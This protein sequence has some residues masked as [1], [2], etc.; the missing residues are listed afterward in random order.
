MQLS[1]SV[2]LLIVAT[3]GAVVQ[4]Q[5][6]E[7]PPKRKLAKLDLHPVWDLTAGHVDLYGDPLPE[8]A[9]TRIGSTRFR[10]NDNVLALAY[11][12]DGRTI[13]AAGWDGLVLW[14]AA[15]GR[16]LGRFVGAAF[17]DVQFLADGKR[18]VTLTVDGQFHF[19]SLSRTVGRPQVGPIAD[20]HSKFTQCAGGLLA[21]CKDRRIVLWDTKLEKPVRTFDE[22]CFGVAASAD[23]KRLASWNGERQ[24][25][26]I[27]LWNPNTGERLRSFSSALKRGNLRS[28]ALSADGKWIAGIDADF[29]RESSVRVWNSE[30]G[31]ETRTFRTSIPAPRR[32]AFAL[33]GKSIALVG[34]Q[35]AIVFGLDTG[36]VRWHASFGRDQPNDVRFAAGGRNLAIAQCFRVSIWDTLS[37]R[38]HIPLPDA[39]HPAF[40]ALS[41]DGG[42]V[43]TWGS[44]DGPL[45]GQTVVVDDIV[46]RLWDSSTGAALEPHSRPRLNLPRPSGL[47]T[48]FEILVGLSGEKGVQT[49]NRSTGKKL[50]T[51]DAKPEHVRLSP[52]GAVYVVNLRSPGN[53]MDA[54]VKM[55][56]HDA[57][58]GALLVPLV[59]PRG[60]VMGSTFSPD[61]KYYAASSPEKNGYCVHIWDIAGRKLERVIEPE[62]GLILAS[63]FSHDS[64]AI[65][66]IAQPTSGSPIRFWDVTTGKPLP[67]PEQSELAQL[68]RRDLAALIFHPDNRRIVTS[69]VHGELRLW[70]RIEGRLLKK[71]NAGGSVYQM[72]FSDNGRV[73]MTV[74][75]SD[76]L[77][78]DLDELVK[79]N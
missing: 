27:R 1:R 32:L 79:K 21:F 19:W 13:A 39:Q 52:N 47:S 7:E 72:S 54:L 10:H 20:E 48:N 24:V 70:D 38:E 63:A 42:T 40:A 26:V 25:N 69:D 64:R 77:V 41:A 44:A 71:W 51:F 5:N 17:N 4:A 61:S 14:D 43:I 59:G 33:D 73:L 3:L 16:R 31:E 37:G 22:A 62:I 60:Y 18:L 68:T 65:G 58:S 11:S 6:P 50:S 9:R 23:G 75:S 57:K 28:P 12:P 56:L 49:W 15:S 46:L 36:E 74:G 53:A 35:D 76:V 45:E 67:I 29:P 66:L 30:T 34:Q 8:S 2:A 78:W 55:E